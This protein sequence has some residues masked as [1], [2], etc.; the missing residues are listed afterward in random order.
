[1]HFSTIITALLVPLL[2]VAEDPLQT[3]TCTSYL[4]LVKT[5]T[6]SKAGSTTVTYTNNSTA[7][8]SATQVPTPLITPPSSI[9]AQA[10]SKPTTTSGASVLGAAHVAVAAIAGVAVAVFL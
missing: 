2:A 5:I 9:T 4:T 7:S 6:L 3:T 10:I 8:F 1:M